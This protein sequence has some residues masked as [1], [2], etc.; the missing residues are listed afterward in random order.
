MKLPVNQRKDQEH[1][2][3]HKTNPKRDSVNRLD[4]KVVASEKAAK[5]Y[6]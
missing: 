2:K 3:N 1:I 6:S 5:D 4:I